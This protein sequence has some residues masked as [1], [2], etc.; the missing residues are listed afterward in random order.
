M[1]R[2]IAPGM[3]RTVFPSVLAGATAGCGLLFPGDPAS[4]P[5]SVEEESG[6]EAESLAESIP[7]GLGALL[8]EEI[9]L[10]LRR[11]E[12]QLMVTP[13]SESITRLAAPDTYERLSALGRGY[14]EIFLE[15]TG[16]AVPF[17][18]FLVTMYS[19]VTELD[20]EPEGLNLVNRG[21]RYRPVDIRPVTPD[22]DSRRLR[23]R[24]SVMAVYAFSREL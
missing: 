12:L 5:Q 18:L 20:F 22:W 7:A 4:L 9:S 2:P 15:E 13:L 11:G 19:E 6:V 17:E 8:Q 23:P 1:T 24:Q 3:R 21:L 14:Q 10:T 16:S